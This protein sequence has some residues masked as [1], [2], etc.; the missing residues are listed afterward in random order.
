[1]AANTCAP[2][3]SPSPAPAMPTAA[4]HATGSPCSPGLRCWHTPGAA[5]YGRS[6]P[7]RRS[8]RA[9]S[10]P[11]TPTPP[12]PGPTT[13]H[14]TCRPAATPASAATPCSTARAILPSCRA[15]SPKKASSTASNSTS[16]PRSGTSW[17][18]LPTARA[19]TVAPKT[20]Q[21]PAPPVGTASGFIGRA[22]RRSKTPSRRSVARGAS[23]RRPPPC[24]AGTTR[25]S[26]ASRQAFPPRPPSVARTPRGSS[27]TIM[28]VPTLS[29][30]LPKPNAL[31]CC[32][33]KPSKRATS[34]GSGVAPCAVLPS[35][36][37]SSS[38]RVRSICSA[39]WV[40]SRPKNTRQTG[41]SCSRKSST[42]A[43]TTCPRTRASASPAVRRQEAPICSLPGSTRSCA[44]KPSRPATA[45]PSKPRAPSCPGAPCS[46]TTPA[47]A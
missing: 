27:P 26:A 9:C 42:P 17:C 41:A 15:C 19:P 18:S 39:R 33:S 10:P 2:A 32:S 43:S 24:S 21:A 44:A 22:A 6:G 47:H 25:P 14:R 7:S 34:A 1:M 13:S 35:A 3:S 30:T 37:R 46:P 28:P 16:P 5:R 29:Q 8:S 31:P 4:S 36:P 38:P 20:R 12:G 23:N 11:T 40:N 45:T